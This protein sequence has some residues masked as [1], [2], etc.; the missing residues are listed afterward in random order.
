MSLNNETFE[1]AIF[2]F[3]NDEEYEV[4]V[5]YSYSGG[6]IEITDVLL[7][8]TEKWYDIGFLIPSFKEQL[9]EQINMGLGD[10]SRYH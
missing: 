8:D 7:Y 10:A 2:I 3:I 9:I 5:S 1:A 4:E 6:S